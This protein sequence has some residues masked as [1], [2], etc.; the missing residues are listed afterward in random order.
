MKKTL[1][2]SLTFPPDTIS[3]GMIVSEIAEGINTELHNVEV[4]ASSPQYNLKSVEL[5]DNSDRN[6]SIGS[7]KNIKVHYIKSKPRKFSNSSRFLQWIEFNFKSILFIYKNR[8]HYDNIFIFSYPPTMNLVCIF[9]SKILKINTVYSLWELYPEI[10]EKLNEE[11]NKILK[12]FFK[13]IDNYA[14][15][16]V[17]KVVVNSDDLKNYL[18]NKRNITANKIN[19]INHFSPFMKSNYVPNFELNNI[20]YAGNTGRPQNL[21][22]FVRY[23]QKHFPSDWKLDIYGAG[24]EFNNLS[25]FSNENIRINNYLERKELENV[26]KEI[27]FAL[28]CLDYEITFEGFPGKTFDYLNMNKVL[29]NFSNPNSVVSKLIDKYGLG[30]NIDLENPESLRGKL[31]DMKS[32]NEIS[33]ILENIK[34]FQESVSN[35]KIA[36]KSYLGL[37][38][39][40][41]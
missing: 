16:T 40:S 7:Y 1:F 38:S 37:I 33:K 31:E 3:T 9:T 34:Y 13:Y 6:L 15:K 35:K 2:H 28:I 4:L 10:A 39:S 41:S 22:A 18:I 29:I 30:F 24:Q 5:F 32:S 20:F 23:F 11:P 19:V 8:T 21:S 14:L 25:E 26:T 17:N 36:F 27:P 12:L